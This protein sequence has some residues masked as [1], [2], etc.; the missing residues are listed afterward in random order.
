MLTAAAA[1]L[2]TAQPILPTLLDLAECRANNHG[3]RVSL[4]DAALNAWTK[5]ISNFDEDRSA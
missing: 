1:L 2:M 4:A 5:R 3:V